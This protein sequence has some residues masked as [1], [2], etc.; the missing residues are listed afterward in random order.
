M[1]WIGMDLI[2]EGLSA[3]ADQE[4]QDLAWTNSGGSLMSSPAE[5][6]EGLF[7]DSALGHNLESGDIVFTEAIDEKLRLLR[8]SLRPIV[9]SHDP[10][11]HVVAGEKMEAVRKMSAK[12]LFELVRHE[13]SSARAETTE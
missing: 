13:A 3:F 2:K 11:E 4:F 10:I 5:D 9:S 1:T 6:Y 8:D 12:I 7:T